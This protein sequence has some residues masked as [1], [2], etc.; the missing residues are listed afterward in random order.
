MSTIGIAQIENAFL[1]SKEIDTAEKFAGRRKQVEQ[2]YLALYAAGAN[3]TII[4]NRGIGKSSLARQ[5]INIASGNNDLLKKLEIPHDGKMDFLTIYFACGGAVKTFQDLL[6]RLLTTQGCLQDWVYEIPSARKEF[7]SLDSKFN[8]QLAS[9]G[10][11]IQTETESQSAITTHSIDTIFTNVVSAIVKEKIAR[12]GILI[13]LDEFDRIEN[14]TGFADFLKA[15]S[16]NVPGVKFCLVGVAQDIQK[17]MKEHGSSDRLFAGGIVYMPPMSKDELM[18]IIDI[19]EKS[20]KNEISFSQGA[21]NEIAN[22]A[23]GHPYMV[24]LLGKHTLRGAFT[25]KKNVVDA[26]DIETTLV[27]IAESEADPVLEGRYKKAVGTSPQR[28]SVLKALAKK[29][30]SD[31]EILTTEAYKQAL[32]WG[33]DNPSQ[34][35]GHLVTDDYGGEIVKIRER[36][37]RFRDSLFLAYVNARPR[38]IELES[39]SENQESNGNNNGG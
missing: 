22:L 27:R 7:K 16:T 11:T 1:P 28:E 34:Y 25:A 4:G 26:K 24:H 30:K 35:V 29:V 33:V 37:Y 2:A 23:Q 32:D 13:V 9:L 8:V 19:A 36:V 38:F 12:D 5:I 15:L 18:E 39:A 21:K 10:G 3:I 20:I 6:F 17:L 14:P 31:G